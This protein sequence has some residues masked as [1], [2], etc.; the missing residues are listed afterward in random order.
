MK[1][2]NLIVEISIPNWNHIFSADFDIN[3]KREKKVILMI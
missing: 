3:T 2:D 1:N